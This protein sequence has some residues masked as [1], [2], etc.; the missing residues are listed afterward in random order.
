MKNIVERA[1][2]EISGFEGI[3][4]KVE[5][6]LINN[7]KS[8]KTYSVYIRQIALICLHF[9]CL[10]FDI[11]DE[12]IAEFLFKVKK[13]NNYSETY[14]KFSVYGLRYLFRIYDLE[15]R[16]VQLPSI[17]R[18]KGLPVVLSQR[19]CKLL[20]QQPTKF[21]DK[22]LLCLTYSAGLRLSEV[23]KLEIRDIDTD[24]MLLHVR[25]GKG[26]KDRYVVLS[27]FISSK[28]AEYCKTYCIDKYLFPGQKKGNYMS[29]TGIQRI[30][31]TAVEKS[32]IRKKAN[33]HTLRHCFATH[34]LE[35]GIDILTVKEQM[36]HS[37]IKTTMTYLQVCNLERTQSISPLDTLYHF[38]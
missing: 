6:E 31:R 2:C 19:E 28:F 15:D 37:D 36:G 22:F 29:K 23:Q 27:K 17:A 14:F 24:R 26:G 33:L 32:G 21:R 10:P 1:V 13:E 5:R 34:L 12:E 30:M 20:F 35:N 18:Y 25:K 16:K 7:G 9:G 3:R 4:H 38:S 8:P 11:T